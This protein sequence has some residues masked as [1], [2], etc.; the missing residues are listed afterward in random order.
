MNKLATENMIKVIRKLSLLDL[1]K[2]QQKRMQ[3]HQ[4]NCARL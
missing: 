4:F 2:I 1:R 3:Y